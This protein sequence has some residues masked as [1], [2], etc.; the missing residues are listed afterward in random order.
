LINLTRRSWLLG[1]SSLGLS[2]KLAAASMSPKPQNRA[3]GPKSLPDYDSFEK[4]DQVY[5]NSGSI[6]PIPTSARVAVDEYLAARSAPGGGSGPNHDQTVLASFAR[7]INADPD[8]VAFVRS[9]TTAEHLIVNGLELAGPGKHIVTDTLHFFGSFPLY[10]GLADRGTE[11]TWVRPRENRIMIEDMRRAIRPDTKLVALSLVSTYNGFQHDLRAV[12]E[13][14][15]AHGA[16]VYA[17][18]IHAAGCVPL[19]VR[20]SGVDFAACASYKWLMGDF[21]LGFVYARRDAQD[22]LVRKRYGYYGV[23]TFQ[24]HVYPGDPPSERAVDFTMKNNATGLFATGTYSHAGV[25]HLDQ[26]LRYILSLGVERINAHAQSLVG[27]LKEELPRLGFHVIT[28]AESPAPI[29]T[30]LVDDTSSL[31]PRLKDTNITLTLGRNRFRVTPSVFN[32]FEHI[33]QLLRVLA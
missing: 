5:L 20:D 10:Q 14:A 15:H 28:P 18:I 1:A 33:D 26:S 21:G 13:I 6:H 23:E 27:Y 24:T 2:T 4:S 32:D 3:A 9:T 31:A 17:D 22:R 30:C 25:I 7:L 11:V 16:L 19:D 29:V 12:C 8:E